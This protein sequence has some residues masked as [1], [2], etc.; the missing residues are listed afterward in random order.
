MQFHPAGI[1]MDS[2][3]PTALL[4]YGCRTRP[5][6]LIPHPPF[7]FI[8]LLT[9]NGGESAYCEGVQAS[10]HLLGYARHPCPSIG[11]YLFDDWYSI[12][13]PS[14]VLGVGY[15]CLFYVPFDESHGDNMFTPV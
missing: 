15:Y 7:H 2:N 1:G 10:G 11:D 5:H 6:P 3:E 14:D 9:R 12:L 4:L 13:S 8:P